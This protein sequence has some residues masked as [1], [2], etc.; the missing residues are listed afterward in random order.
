MEYRQLGASG[1]KVP[2]LS[3]GTGTFGGS[4]ELFKAWG[5]TDV[6][7]GDQTRRHLP[8]GRPDDVRLG[9]PVLRRDGRGDPRP[10]DQGPARPG[11][12]LDQGDVPGRPGAQRRRLV[13]GPPDPGG[14]GEPEAAR[15]RSH[16]PVPAP[17]LRRVDPDRGN[18]GDPRP[19]REGGQ[20]PLH[21]LLQL[22]RL[23][24]D[25]VAGDLREVRPQPVRRAPGLLLADRPRLRVGADAPGDRPG[26][27]SGGLEPPGL[28]PADRQDPPGPAPAPRAAGSRARP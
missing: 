25:E 12:D 16:R 10:G 13:A 20:D 1:F 6:A 5:Q 11:P 22:L 7:R 8:R 2:V 18:P 14:R 4:G 28:G 17:R 21:R 23:A 26:D 19:P 27:R 24:P 9:R 15:D 3:F